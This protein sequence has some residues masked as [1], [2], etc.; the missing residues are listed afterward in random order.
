LDYT[1][2]DLVCQKTQL[3]TVTVDNNTTELTIPSFD[4]GGRDIQWIHVYSASNS[5]TLTSN[6][7]SSHFVTTF[8]YSAAGLLHSNRKYLFQAYYLTRSSS[9]SKATFPIY[10]T[11]NDGYYA[12]LNNLDKLASG[13]ASILINNSNTT[14]GYWKGGTTYYIFIG[15]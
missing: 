8:V 14:V 1:T 15:G 4:I 12:T 3:F 6:T 7:T 5:V 9:N 10:S 2:F 11:A 13:G